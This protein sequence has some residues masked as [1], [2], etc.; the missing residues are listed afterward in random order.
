MEDQKHNPNLAQ[1]DQQLTL[2]VETML[3]IRALLIVSTSK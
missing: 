2:A 3:K 1:A